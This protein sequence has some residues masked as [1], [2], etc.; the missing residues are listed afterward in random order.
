MIQT[1]SGPR[2]PFW[3]LLWTQAVDADMFHVHLKESS[4]NEQAAAAVKL[5]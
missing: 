1:S 2:E 4:L 5:N 3:C